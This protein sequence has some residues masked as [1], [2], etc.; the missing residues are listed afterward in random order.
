[1]VSA[2]LVGFHSFDDGRHFLIAAKRML[3]YAAHTRA[4]GIWSLV[5]GDREVVISMKHVS[6]EC[7]IIDAVVAHPQTQRIVDSIRQR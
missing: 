5:V 4:G 6:V 1:M 7:D 3:G 2:D